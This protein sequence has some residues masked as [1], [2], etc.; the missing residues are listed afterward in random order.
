MSENQPTIGKRPM[1]RTITALITA[2]IVLFGGFVGSWLFRQARSVPTEVPAVGTQKLHSDLQTA[3]EGSVNN[4]SIQTIQ[5]DWNVISMQIDGVPIRSVVS[6]MTF[7]GSKLT[8]E[9]ITDNGQ[10]SE[11]ETDFV[12]DT[13]NVPNRLT[14]SNPTSR[15]ICKFEEGRLLIAAFGRPDAPFPSEF[16]IKGTDEHLVVQVLERPLADS[17]AQKRSDKL[18]ASQREGLADGW[19]REVEVPAVIG[20]SKEVVVPAHKVTARVTDGWLLAK[21]EDDKG[22]PEWEVVL[23]Q[24]I[25][26]H[27]PQID[28]EPN[29]GFISLQYGPYFV[30]EHSGHLRILRERKSSLK[31]VC[32]VPAPSSRERLLVSSDRLFMYLLGNSLWVAAG[33]NESVADVQLR[34]QHKALAEKGGMAS[35][36]FRDGKLAIVT[37]GD[38]TC[39]DDGDLLVATRIPTYAAKSAIGKEEKR[40]VLYA[41]KA[42]A[43][44]ATRWFNAL[45][46]VDLEALKGKVVLID[47]W[48]T[49]CGPCVK[50]LPHV[51]SLYQKF[52]DQGLVVIGIHSATGSD[53]LE[54]FLQSE[55]FH[56]PVCIDTGISAESYAVEAYPSYFLVDKAGVVVPGA[57]GTPPSEEQIVELLTSEMP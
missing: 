19:F 17:N 54:N 25:Y 52:K 16:S 4:K 20:E 37:C 28:I 6:T 55:E 23:S 36:S 49:W 38:A 32:S 21:C 3:F 47:F 14:F 22:E 1:P 34:F 13:L 33:R 26:T 5:G 18:P 56:F 50:N 40:A 42:P 51:E 46:P 30:R 15:A 29:L 11:K 41:G 43:I 44:H 39:Q 2:A 10:T 9:F 24:A 7:D 8:S 27:P 53:R 12:L 35:Q 57:T 31:P 45:E 48:G